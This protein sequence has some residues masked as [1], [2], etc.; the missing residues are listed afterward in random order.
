MI[1][2]AILYATTT[3]TA[4]AVAERAADVVR[5]CGGLGELIDAADLRARPRTIDTD[6]VIVVGSVHEGQHHRVLRELLAAQREALQRVPTLLLSVSL[7]AASKAELLRARGYIETLVEQTGWRPTRS[8]P[9]A[10]ALRYSRYDHFTRVTM[11]V[12]AGATGFDADASHDYEYTDWD[13]L[14]H[15][16]EELRVLIEPVVRT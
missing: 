12:I 5:R 7:A 11:R 15:A 2:I 8:L 6:A 13:Q 14:E 16:V 3:G 1:R 9:V 10:G 4:R